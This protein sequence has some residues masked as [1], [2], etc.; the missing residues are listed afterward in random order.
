VTTW[1]GYQETDRVI[2]GF[3]PDEE[4][5][6]VIVDVGAAHPVLMS[7]SHHFRECG[8]T[9][10]PVEP[11]P[12]FCAMYEERGWPVLQYA[13]SNRDSD[14]VEFNVTP[15]LGHGIPDTEGMPHSSLGSRYNADPAD[16]HEK[17]KVRVRKLDTLLAEH[18]PALTAI[19]V[20]TVDVEG[21]EPE[22]IEGIN[23]VK[24]AP[25]V[26]VLEEYEGR[27]YGG[28]MHRLG[29]KVAVSLEND[30]LYVPA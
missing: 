17:I 23:I 7:N 16:Q 13:A 22:V 24:L 1:Y 25:K 2:R 21:W 30:K 15:Y 27:D 29:Y 10:I 26:V 5:K 28:L 9:V 6:G 3:F 14:D 4:Y 20:L 18:Y 12:R 19:D 8:W 11:N